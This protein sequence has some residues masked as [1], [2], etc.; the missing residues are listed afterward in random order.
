MNGN[1]IIPVQVEPDGDGVIMVLHHPVD[2]PVVVGRVDAVTGADVWR[3]QLPPTG[4]F[5]GV[6]LAVDGPSLQ[7]VVEHVYESAPGVNEPPLLDVFDLDPR[8]GVARWA[9]QIPQDELTPEQSHERYRFSTESSLELVP[10]GFN[11]RISTLSLGHV[12]DASDGGVRRM[13]E[14]QRALATVAS[15][16]FMESITMPQGIVAAAGGTVALIR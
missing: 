9:I 2:G 1:E 3:F 8:T 13:F 6:D 12:L 14:L 7:V 15:G 10:A 5:G 16:D 4:G 11:I